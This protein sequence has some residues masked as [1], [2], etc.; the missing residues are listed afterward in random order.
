M[1]YGDFCKAQKMWHKVLTSFSGDRKKNP[2]WSVEDST[3]VGK[4]SQKHVLLLWCSF[5]KLVYVIKL[6]AL[7]REIPNNNNLLG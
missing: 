6:L 4:T 5:K 3:V 7:Y 2:W 1:A